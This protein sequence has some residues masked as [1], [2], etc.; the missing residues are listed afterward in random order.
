MWCPMLADRGPGPAKPGNG[1][2]TVTRVRA[3]ERESAE[4]AE[5]YETTRDDCARIALLNVGDRHLGHD[6]VAEA[7]ARAWMSW[8]KVRDFEVP[9]AWVVR[10]APNAHVSW[11]RR[12]R[13]EI[14]LGDHDGAAAGEQ[15]ARVSG[16]LLRRDPRGFPGRRGSAHPVRPAI[17]VAATSCRDCGS[18]AGP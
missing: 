11:R 7:Y 18:T 16:D 5:F 6:L 2:S 9:R 1:I 12:R 8:R 10:T 3:M 17:A 15:A 14:S 4:F 13:R